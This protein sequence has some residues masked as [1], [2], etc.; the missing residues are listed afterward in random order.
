MTVLVIAIAAGGLG[1][2]DRAGLFGQRAGGGDTSRYH[3]KTFRVS[4]VV[5]GDT[6]D[7]ATPDGQRAMTRVRLWGVDTPECVRPDWPIEH[8]GPEASAFTKRVCA[9]KTVRVDLHF[10]ETRCKYGRLLAYVI[11]PDGTCLNEQ[12]IVQGYGY[13]DLRY[14]HPRYKEFIAAMRKA[15]RDG[16]G[17]WREVT[18]EQMPGYL[19][20]SYWPKRPKLQP[21]EEK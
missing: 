20:E 13:A 11:L 19:P 21:A 14:P 4:R 10:S 8:F 7:L 9:G 12:L 2:L 15:R 5:D 17:L 1:L 16:T 18:G 3:N 6:I